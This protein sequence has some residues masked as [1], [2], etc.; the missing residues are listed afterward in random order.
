MTERNY[1]P[2]NLVICKKIMVLRTALLWDIT[3]R[4]VIISYQHFGTTL[5]MG[6]ISCSETSV[7]EW[8]WKYGVLN[9]FCGLNLYDLGAAMFAVFHAEQSILRIQSRSR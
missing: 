1:V 8:S 5:S 7:I 4:V 3:Q 9:V 6:P 2:W